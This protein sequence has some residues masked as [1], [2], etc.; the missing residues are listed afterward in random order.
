MKFEKD[1]G[2]E[3][4][5]VI[6]NFFSKDEANF[7]IDYINNNQHILTTDTKTG[8]I[9]QRIMFGRNGYDQSVS[10]LSFEKIKD[11][12]PFV[13]E[14][15]FSRVEAAVEKSYN[16]K[17]MISS[18]FLV[19]Q[20]EGTT[21]PEHTDSDSGFNMQLEYGGVIYLNSMSVG[22]KLKFPEFNYE[23]KPEAG[24]LVI[25]P[26]KPPQYRHFVERINEDRYTVPVWVTKYPFFKL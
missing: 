19:K 6:K 5:K 7:L 13:R 9:R 11:I 10:E 2:I 16:K 17:L 1:M 24:D 20:H 12:E 15:I 4:I 21:V 8:G 14:A 26:S 23:Y 22:G 3:E 18:F 25:F